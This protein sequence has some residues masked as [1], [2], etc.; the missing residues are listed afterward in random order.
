MDKLAA[1]RK[2]VISEAPK[3]T[4]GKRVYSLA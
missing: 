1:D 3:G 4:K 2:V